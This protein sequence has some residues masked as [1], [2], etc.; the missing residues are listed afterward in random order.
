MNE[1][2][3]ND[4]VLDGSKITFSWSDNSSNNPFRKNDFYFDYNGIALDNT[5]RNILWS[6]FL[7]CFI[8]VIRSAYESAIIIL[9]FYSKDD[10]VKPWIEFHN[11]KNVHYIFTGAPLNTLIN[12]P[13]V[14][15]N[16]NHGVL[17]GGGKDSLFTYNSVRDVYNIEG[18]KHVVISYIFPASSSFGN[19]IETRRENF[20]FKPL[21]K[22]Y[23]NCVIQFIKTDI[24]LSVKDEF[25]FAFHTGIYAGTCLPACLYHDLSFVTFSFEFTHFWTHTKENK[26][27]PYFCTSRP[28]SN[29]HISKYLSKLLGYNFKFYNFNYPISEYF[30]FKEIVRKYSWSLPALTM[31][32]G[33]S[34][35]EEKYCYKCTKCAEYFLYNLSLGIIP[36]DFDIVKFFESNTYIE[37]IINKIDSESFDESQMWYPGLTFVLHYMSFRHV[38]SKINARQLDG[39]IDEKHIKKLQKIIDTYGK[40]YTA[41]IESF[42]VALAN[43]ESPPELVKYAR[44]LS[45]ENAINNTNKISILYGNSTVLVDCDYKY[46]VSKINN[47]IEY[48]NYY[49]EYKSDIDSS[50]KTELINSLCKGQKRLSKGELLFKIVDSAPIEG[51]FCSLNMTANKK[52]YPT[53]LIFTLENGYI[54]KSNKGIISYVILVNDVIYKAFDM[55][56][57]GNNETFK[58]MIPKDCECKLEIKILSNKNTQPWNWGNASELKMK[59]LIRIESRMI[60]T[61]ISLT[62]TYPKEVIL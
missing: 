30:A 2:I 44:T 4:F 5:D 33:T 45:K 10:I 47:S 12:S 15:N 26:E 40:D 52:P 41:E 11:A 35:V 50:I 56:D 9:P 23:D 59:N 53:D 21:R 49:R 48:N 25:L 17:Y 18:N 1:I 28:E 37:K 31:C 38:L 16:L 42:H 6:V 57:W 46:Q 7:S 62:T 54:N 14:S 27:S 51:A 19:D 13:S 3:V 29:Q 61:D 39:L 22:I 32:E 34:S 58:L 20:I 55:C 24:R 36:V 60:H 8:P 43:Q